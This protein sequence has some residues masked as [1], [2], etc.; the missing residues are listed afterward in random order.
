MM[1]YFG[2]GIVSSIFVLAASS[3][4]SSPEKIP[5]PVLVAMHGATT[6]EILQHL[7]EVRADIEA[8]ERKAAPQSP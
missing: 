4:M 8:S 6:A 5:Q 2:A 7:R 3:Q 1:H